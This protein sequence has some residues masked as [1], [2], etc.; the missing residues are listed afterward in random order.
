MMDGGGWDRVDELKKQLSEIEGI[1][2]RTVFR[3]SLQYQAEQERK[4]TL[5]CNVLSMVAVDGW[6]KDKLRE[7][8][9]KALEQIAPARLAGQSVQDESKESLK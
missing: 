2:A 4:L 7:E 8:A 6:T 1:V 5:A 9:V 3:S